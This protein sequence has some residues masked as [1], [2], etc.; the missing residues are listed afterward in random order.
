MIGKHKWHD[1]IVAMADGL[2]AQYEHNGVWYKLTDKGVN[3]FSYPHWQ[4]RIKPRTI[5]IGDMEVPEPMRVAPPEGTAVFVVNIYSVPTIIVW[6]RYPQGIK[7]ME[8]G[9]CH[10]DHDAAI[11]HGKALIKISG[12]NV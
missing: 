11:A 6:G 8:V 9:M 12:G 10:L 1:V 3:P 7:W 2:D 5:K 4:W